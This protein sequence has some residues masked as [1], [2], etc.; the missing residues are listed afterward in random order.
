MRWKLEAT[1][2]GSNRRKFWNLTQC[3]SSSL[4][5][6]DYWCRLSGVLLILYRHA[7]EHMYTRFAEQVPWCQHDMYPYRLVC[8]RGGSISTASWMKTA[9]EHFQRVQGALWSCVQMMWAFHLP[10]VHRRTFR[11]VK[12]TF[13]RSTCRSKSVSSRFSR[14][15]EAVQ[16]M[17]TSRTS[18]RYAYFIFR[19]INIVNYVMIP[20]KIA[21]PGINCRTYIGLLALS[22]D[23]LLDT[24]H[25]MQWFIFKH[26]GQAAANCC[27]STVL[28]SNV[29]RSVTL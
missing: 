26:S 27:L 10:S 3:S 25:L 21:I 23:F 13:V 16:D 20:S 14:T 24:Q 12:S 6:Y 1:T 18:F 11:S 8:S 2:T 5:T 29:F 4:T 19:I 9:N 28:M 15:W 7:A 22:T 17:Q